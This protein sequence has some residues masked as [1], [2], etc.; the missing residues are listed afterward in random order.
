MVGIRR[1]FAL[2]FLGFYVTQFT[3]TALLGP[4]EL[5]ACYLGLA[6]CYLAAFFGL[7]AA[8]STDGAHAG[9]GL[10]ASVE[11]SDIADQ[12]RAVPGGP[13]L[14]EFEIRQP[15]GAVGDVTV[16]RVSIYARTPG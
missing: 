8:S 10:S 4:D 13:G 1:A 16:D 6:L 2:L 15:D 12:L 9:N 3:M 11:I 14:V 7:A 5:F